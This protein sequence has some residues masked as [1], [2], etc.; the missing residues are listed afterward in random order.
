MGVA[1][2]IGVGD[3]RYS[4]EDRGSGKKL[5]DRWCEG[6]A[7]KQH[8]GM[9]NIHWWK[10]VETLAIWVSRFSTW[11]LVTKLLPC[12]NL[13]SPNISVFQSNVMQKSK[14][15][16]ASAYSNVTQ[17]VCTNL[18]TPCR[19]TSKLFV[20]GQWHCVTT[21]SRWL[22][23]PTLLPIVID[24][25]RGV[26]VLLK[27][28]WAPDIVEFVLGRFSHFNIAITYSNSTFCGAWTP[29]FCEFTQ[30]FSKTST[31]QGSAAVLHDSCS[32]NRTIMSRGDHETG[33]AA[34]TCDASH[35]NSK[36]HVADKL[37][38]HKTYTF[39]LRPKLWGCP[40]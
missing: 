33:G 4:L 37:A 18:G 28:Y 21:F 14:K 12:T 22:G 16:K 35:C 36:Q 30:N 11:L 8:S 40:C 17:K 25:P 10:A 1:K 32:I 24:H 34:K 23:R 20:F 9:A 6:A 26:L 27:F 38:Q 3:N 5:E 29:S 2:Q 13:K 19:T 31:P 7:K 39:Y 15:V